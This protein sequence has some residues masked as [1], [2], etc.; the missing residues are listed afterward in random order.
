MVLQFVSAFHTFT[1]AHILLLIRQSKFSHYLPFKM[2]HLPLIAVCT[3]AY[4]IYPL[5]H[6]Q[7][8]W[9]SSFD[10][11]YLTS[12]FMKYILTFVKAV[13]LILKHATILRL[14]NQSPKSALT[15]VE[16]DYQ[17]ADIDLKIQQYLM[18]TS[19]EQSIEQFV[20]FIMATDIGLF[21]FSS[22]KIIISSSV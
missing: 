1:Q 22:V 3:Y 7:W 14:S 4:D 16:R 5:G 8:S 12:T 13:I 21:Y 10:L 6:H 11:W 9:I 17:R 2:Y 20:H 15:S 19:Q 18:T